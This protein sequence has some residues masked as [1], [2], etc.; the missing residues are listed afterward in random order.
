MSVRFVQII[1]DLDTL[2][3]KWLKVQSLTFKYEKTQLLREWLC[4]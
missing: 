1:R 4:I 3:N 2:I